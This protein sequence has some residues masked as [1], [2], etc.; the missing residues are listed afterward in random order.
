MTASQDRVHVWPVP[1]PDAIDR[2]LTA[3]ITLVEKAVESVAGQ[4]RVWAEL[5]NPDGSLLPG[6][7]VT[8][9]VYPGL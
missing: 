9:V 3:E 2:Q 6:T 5:P 4:V 1:S 8:L 7:N